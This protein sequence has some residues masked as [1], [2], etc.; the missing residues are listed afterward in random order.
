MARPRVVVDKGEI[1][2][3]FRDEERGSRVSLA[4]ARE[5]ADDE[6][7]VSDLTDFSVDAW[8]PSFDTE[9]WKREHRLHL[10]VQQTKQGDGERTVEIEPQP[11]YVLEVSK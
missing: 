1:F 8:E 4:R 2:Y 5:A 9:L 7:S 11:V 3:L 6:W 10:F